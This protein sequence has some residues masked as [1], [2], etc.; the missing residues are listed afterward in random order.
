MDF[1]KAFDEVDHQLLF[2]K[3]MKLGISKSAIIL[4]SIFSM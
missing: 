3:L 1:S 2:Y 4:D